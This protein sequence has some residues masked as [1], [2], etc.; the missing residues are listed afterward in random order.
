MD[1]AGSD[2]QRAVCRHPVGPPAGQPEARAFQV[3]QPIPDVVERRPAILCAGARLV[4]PIQEENCV[5]PLRPVVEGLKVPDCDISAP[6][7]RCLGLECR[8]LAGARF[9]DRHVRRGV[10]IAAQRRRALPRLR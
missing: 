6:P 7:A 9:G 4:E 2:R 1:A 8:C 5:M 10:G 3:V